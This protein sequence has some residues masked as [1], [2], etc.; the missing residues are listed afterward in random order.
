MSQEVHR[1]GPPF[2]VV[3]QVSQRCQRVRSTESSSDLRILDPIPCTYDPCQT[4]ST[5]PKAE[6][7]LGG[8]GSGTARQGFVEQ[9]L[10]SHHHHLDPALSESCTDANGC[11]D[12]EA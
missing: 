12:V 5:T 2:T 1:L 4:L 8:W 9:Q 11:I 10:E 3:D 7:W 6:E